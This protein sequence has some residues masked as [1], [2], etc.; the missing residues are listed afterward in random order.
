MPESLREE[1][2]RQF[3]DIDIYW[4]DQ[5]LKGRVVRGMP[6]LD[7]GCGE[8]RNLVY[9]LRTG[10][11]VWGVDRS[12]EAIEKTRLLASQLAPTLPADRF[13]VQPLERLSFDDGEFDCVISSAVLHFAR[14]EGQWWEMVQEM[15]RVLAPGG[16]L[17]ARLA[18]KIGHETR[19]RPLGG[20]LYVLPDGSERFLVDEAFLLDATKRLGGVLLDPIKTTVV[21]DARSM[22]TWVL[23]K[24]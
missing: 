4:F 15:W 8:G 7:A 10:G 9:L 16:F 5:L 22:T 3:G 13:S 17:F 18:S 11:D 14:G 6:I 12:P 1:L 24:R 19:V 20:G 23:R 21:Q 2:R